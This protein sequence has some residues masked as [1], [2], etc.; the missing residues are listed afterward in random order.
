MFIKSFALFSPLFFL[1]AGSCFA[2]NVEVRTD[3]PSSQYL[4]M[5]IDLAGHNFVDSFSVAPNKS[6]SI[7]KNLTD[8]RVKKDKVDGLTKFYALVAYSL[9]TDKATL[10]G[11]R[12]L[13]VQCPVIRE[14]YLDNSVFRDEMIDGVMVSAMRIDQEILSK[15]F[16]SLGTYSFLP[17]PDNV[18]PK[19]SNNFPMS[20]NFGQLTPIELIPL[21][22]MCVQIQSVYVDYEWSEAVRNV[23]LKKFGISE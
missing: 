6:L 20:G 8:V 11:P 15:T 12:F 7:H 18:E 1:T 2:E 22:L 21:E 9:D 3:E 4:G 5:K 16:L 14:T 23:T 10:L 19:L 13:S 17:S